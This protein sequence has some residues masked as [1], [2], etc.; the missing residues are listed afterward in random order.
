[1]KSCRGLSRGAAIHAALA[2]VALLSCSLVPSLGEKS[3]RPGDLLSDLLP[4]T[5]R[6]AELQEMVESLGAETYRIRAEATKELLEATV[7]P[8]RVMEKG[9]A[10]GNPEI[11][12]RM[13]RV[14]KDGA[15]QHA[16]R[17]FVEALRAVCLSEE[18]GLLTRVEAVIESGIPLE[19]LHL[20]TKAVRLTVKEV[21]LPLVGEMAGQANPQRRGL[22]VAA[23]AGIGP[24]ALNILRSLGQDDDPGVRLEAAVEL[25]NLKSRR[26]VAILGEFLSSVDASK[27]VRS[28]QAL[29]ALTGREFGY[30]ALAGSADRKEPEERWRRFL[31]SEF[32]IT[33]EVE[34]D[35][36]VYL[37]NGT[38]LTG[39]T[40]YRR[41]RMLEEGKVS[42][43]VEDGVLT[44][45]GDGPGDLRTNALYEDYLLKVSYR[46]DRAGADSGVGI[47]LQPDGKGVDGG[48]YLEV[49]LLPGRTGDLYRIGNFR[50]EAGGKK[51]GFSHRRQ[52]DRPERLN[53]WHELR[54]E[55]R[56]GEVKVYLDGVL[57]NEARGPRGG[58]KILLREETTKFEFRSI[59]LQP[60]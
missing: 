54:L 31:E 52:V 6:V 15:N 48:D 47:M 22:A 17:A 12:E 4:D 55:V 26:G 19:D 16:G 42:W 20:A 13:R 46:S 7:I 60:L 24:A 34:A 57:V 49:Q 14:M 1:M 51:I 8:K 3:G 44:C 32:E 45:P 9:L 23:A 10:S 53:E 28:A 39:W 38:D 5:G 27:R 33:G 30:Q 59:T 43:V 50:G 25:G 2:V 41:G 56:K 58:G 36:L 29:R 18:K 37:F 21:D 35:P 11:R 40:P